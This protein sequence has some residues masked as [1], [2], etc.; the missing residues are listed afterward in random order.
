M[1]QRDLKIGLAL[2][3]VIVAG[4]IIKLAIDP[5]L[6]TE[7]RMMSRID[8]NDNLGSIDFNNTS[9]NNFANEVTLDSE[10]HNQSEPSEDIPN[11]EN[12][13]EIANQNNDDI[14]PYS[15]VPIPQEQAIPQIRTQIDLPGTS[16]NNIEVIEEPKRFHVVQKDQTLSSISRIYYGSPNQWQKIVNA[17]PDLIPN[18]NKI[19]PGMK[20]IIP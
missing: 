4:V 12:I 16:N 11:K 19:K 8:S 2:G 18:P 7:A 17:N 15:A 3:L 9:Q 10:T 5:R 14:I 1:I 6:S 13:I 20:L